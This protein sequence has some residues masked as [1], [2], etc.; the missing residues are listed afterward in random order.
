MKILFISL[1]TI[2]ATF[3]A[4][5]FYLIYND[6]RLFLIKSNPMED[7]FEAWKTKY[8]KKYGN[9]ENHYKFYVFE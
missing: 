6:N 2:S 9:D 3:F 4:Y 5:V 8:G 1:L 7:R